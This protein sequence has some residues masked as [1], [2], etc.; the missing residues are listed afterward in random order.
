M[1]EDRGDDVGV[2][3]AG[4][5][6]QRTAALGAG[7]DRAAFGSIAN[8][9]FNRCIHVMGASGW[10]GFAGSGSRLGTI[11]FRCLQFGANTP[12][13]RVRLSLGRGTSAARRATKSSGCAKGLLEANDDL[14]TFVHREPFV[15]DGGSGDVAAEF[16]ELVALVGFAAGCGVQGKT[17]LP[18]EQG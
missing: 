9:R 7:L 8:T 4:D 16:F 18:G 6:A 1:L 14:P 3:D 13:K 10:P 5:D 15:G 2:L 17:R 12:W 11:R